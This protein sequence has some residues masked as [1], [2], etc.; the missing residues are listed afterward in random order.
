MV[1]VIRDYYLL[2]NGYEQLTNGHLLLIVH[3]ELMVDSSL[4]NA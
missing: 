4:V 1:T 2:G 3:C